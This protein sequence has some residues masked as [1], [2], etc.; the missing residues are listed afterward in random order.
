[1]SDEMWKAPN[2]VA[3]VQSLTNEQRDE[4]DRRLAEFKR[5]PASAIPWSEARQRL[6]DRFG[7]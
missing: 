2:L 3:S 1:M 6:K 7:A 4:L 5:D